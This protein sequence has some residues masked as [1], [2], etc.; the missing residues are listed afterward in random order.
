MT[1]SPSGPAKIG[2]F[3]TASRDRIVHG[4]GPPF[5]GP[6]GVLYQAAVLSALGN[7][8][9]LHGHCGDDLLAEMDGLAASW[10]GLNTDGLL[11]LAQPANR[12]HLQYP[13]E[14]EREEILEW[15]VPPFKPSLLADKAPGWE[16]FLC[17]MNSGFDMAF[18]DWRQTLAGLSCPVWFDIHS[19]VLEP[20][21]GRPR[22]HRTVP[23]WQAW[24]KGVAWLQASRREVACLAGHPERLPTDKEALD[25]ARQALDLGIRAVF[26]TLGPE[27]AVAAVRGQT[28]YLSSPAAGPAVDTTGC[29][30]VFAAAT[31]AR[32]IRGESPFEA[33]AFGAAL[34]SEAA[35]L[36]GIRATW[37]MASAHRLGSRP[38]PEGPSSPAEET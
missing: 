8:V 25:F 16:A 7:E 12:V 2:L 9:F 17:V 33:A 20:A 35:L 37:T 14:G 26:V 30:A 38:R 21:I 23:D 6:G 15:A 32:L 1:N 34:A 10:P 27:G 29:G 18:K 4:D 24:V 31:L 5:D 36:T 19:L 3:G 28:Q 22:G 11:F 13:P